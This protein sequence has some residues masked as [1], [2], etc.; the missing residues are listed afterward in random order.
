MT[1]SNTSPLTNLAAVGQLTLLRRLYG[2]IVIPEAVA[3]ELNSVE[4]GFPGHV[5]VNEL[6]WIVIRPVINRTLVASLRIELD[7]GES[8]AIALAVELNAD[9]LLMDEHVG[10]RIAS[11]LGVERVGVLGVLRR[12]KHD[13]LVPAIRPILDDLITS[14]GFWIGR[15]LYDYALREAGE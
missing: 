13:G 11:R 15:D 8:E 2:E 5:P 1:V 12:A 14:A 10:R 9:F 6:S 7:P 4:S 3:R